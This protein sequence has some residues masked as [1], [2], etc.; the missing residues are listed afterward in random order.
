MI[1]KLTCELC[2]RKYRVVLCNRQIRK[3]CMRV[4]WYEETEAIVCKSC[5]VFQTCRKMCTKFSLTSGEIFKKY[6]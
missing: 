6:Y 5:L 2:N 4:Q 3:T 1:S